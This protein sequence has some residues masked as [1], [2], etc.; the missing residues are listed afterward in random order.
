MDTSTPVLV[1]GGGPTG[2]TA[3]RLL[4]NLNIPHVLIERRQGPQ[5]APAAHVINRRTME[6]FRQAG[7]DMD[8]IYALN[9]HGD[10]PLA[11]RWRASLNGPTIAELVLD[12]PKAGAPSPETVTNISQPLLEDHLIKE[13]R[14][15]S[16][17]DLRFG[18]EW[19]GFVDGDTTRSLVRTP[20]GSTVVISST[21]T[22]AADGAGSPVRRT[23]GIGKKGRDRLATFLNL[24][25]EV[26]RSDPDSQ[27]HD[28]LT[29]CLDPKF[30]GVVITHDPKRLTVVM[31]QIH[32]PYE[33]PDDYDEPTCQAMLKELFG[34]D[35]PFTLLTRDP[36]HMTA[37]VATKFRE[38]NVF[39]IGDAAH[40]FPP[41]GG[42]G[43][44]SGVA[45]AHNLSWKIS[46][47]MAGAA[48]ALLDTYEAERMPVVERNCDASLENFLR[49][50][51][52]IV[53]I[54]LDA[55]K[56][57]LPAR[58]LAAPPLRSLPKKLRMWLFNVLTAP[59]RSILAKSAADTPAGQKRRIAIQQAA[60]R[61]MPHFDMP[62]LELGYSYPAGLAIAA[63]S[64]ER[65]PHTD[66]SGGG[67]GSVLNRFSYGGYTLLTGDA[68]QTLP[69]FN[70]FGLP[71][72]HIHEPA[73]GLKAGEWVLVRPDGHIAD[74]SNVRK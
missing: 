70:T 7:M 38:G 19:V 71:V 60:N 65:Y 5:P 15:S 64:G 18:Y 32:E 61:Q 21:Y 4:S 47:H 59:A 36:W 53:A 43:L 40:R 31:R 42:L 37:Q 20:D 45:D 10:H 66:I 34:K 30:S 72:E 74:Q 16:L 58:L 22:L 55:E 8:A 24:S 49:M 6:I 1:I 57:S 35:N 41:T 54:G 52:V 62:E 50:D 11:I 3:S 14:L 2:L 69:S 27:T 46:A 48:D 63:G 33:S 28:L 39:L 73:L 56:A 9:R 25:C 51:E 29:W 23:L 13:A 68:A 26:D 44:N 17:G 12:P 67:E